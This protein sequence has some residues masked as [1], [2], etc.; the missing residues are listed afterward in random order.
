MATAL[1]LGTSAYLRA[2]NLGGTGTAHDFLDTIEWMIYGVAIASVFW[3]FRWWALVS[4]LAPIAVTV[5]LHSMSNYVSP[6]GEDEAVS[7]APQFLILLIMAAAVQVAVLSLG[8]L[9]RA[10]WE[11]FRSRRRHNQRS[12]AA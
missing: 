3:V 10:F 6:W 9:L 4:A 1:L 12:G 2:A 5:Y 8:L 11:A 7:T